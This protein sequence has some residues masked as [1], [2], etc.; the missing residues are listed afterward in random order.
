MNPLNAVYLFEYDCY[1]Y[2]VRFYI[3]ISGN[4]KVRIYSLT[5]GDPLHIIGMKG[6]DNGQFLQP[7]A[8]CFLQYGNAPIVV[9][10]DTNNR[11]QVCSR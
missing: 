5:T 6:S 11:L 2:I 1:S 10:G 8:L 9:V 7:I 4:N 3:S